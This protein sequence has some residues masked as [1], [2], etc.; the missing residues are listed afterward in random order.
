M[1][2]YMIVE[3]IQLNLKTI[4]DLEKNL[5]QGKNNSECI[6]KEF[7][8]NTPDIEIQNYIRDELGGN[9]EFNL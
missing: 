6:T 7:P 2:K 8:L 9:S 5:K 3:H 4:Y 1:L